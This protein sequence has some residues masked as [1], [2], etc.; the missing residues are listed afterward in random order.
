MKKHSKRNIGEKLTIYAWVYLT[1]SIIILCAMWVVFLT[2]SKFYLSIFIIDLFITIIDIFSIVFFLIIA[3]N[4]DEKIELESR[5]KQER[6]DNNKLLYE[7]MNDKI[8]KLEDKIKELE[9]GNKE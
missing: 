7:I 8:S 6:Q 1:I 5:Q 9:K 3:E 2:L 4:I